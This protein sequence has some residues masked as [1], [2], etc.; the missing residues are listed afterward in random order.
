[1]NYYD[2]IEQYEDSFVYLDAELIQLDIGEFKGEFGHFNLPSC[3]VETRTSAAKHIHKSA[4]GKGK[5]S[6]IFPNNKESDAMQINGFTMASD[7]QIIDIGGEGVHAVIPA[8][9]NVSV[10]VLEQQKLE[11]ELGQNIA[12]SEN[13]R[14]QAVKEIDKFIIANN[15]RYALRQFENKIIQKSPIA[16]Y[17]LESSLYTMASLYLHNNVLKSGL[18]KKSI[19]AIEKRRV[20]ELL[21]SLPIEQLNVSNL[22]KEA[23]L[24]LRKLHYLCTAT[25]GLTPNQLLMNSRFRRINRVLSAEDLDNKPLISHLLRSLGVTNISRFNL[26]YQRLFGE[27]PKQTML[28]T[29]YK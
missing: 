17:D 7:N 28:R 26:A 22:A 14:R 9:F 23:F 6:L 10:I 12:N 21:F 24:S 3:M 29:K 18:C 15:V 25:W 4:I 8:N 13:L 5:V 16:K 27:T 20:L 11:Q 2:T 1:V 19:K